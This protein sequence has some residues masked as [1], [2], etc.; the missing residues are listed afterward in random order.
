MKKVV[1]SI[2]LLIFF[3]S[4]ANATILEDDFLFIHHSCGSNWLSDGLH[5]SLLSKPYVHE[6][7]DITYGT[8]L[9]P[10]IGRPDSLAPTP[11][12]KTDMNHWLYW[13]NDYLES[14]KIHG[15][16][17]GVNNIIMFKSCYPTSDVVSDGTEPGNPFSSTKTITNYKSIFRK[18]DG[19]TYTNNGNIYYPL[20]DIF[21]QNPQTLFIIC[22]APPLHQSA[23]SDINGYR[24]RTFNDWLSN[25]WID[26]Y[27]AEYP[28]HDNVMVYD[29][30]DFLA[31]G[32][33]ETP[34]N[35]L[36]T[37]YG[38]TSGDSHPNTF[39]N[40]ESTTHFSP[41]LDSA[42]SL[43]NTYTGVNL[44]LTS[45]NGEIIPSP[46]MPIGGYELGTEVT[47]SAVADSGYH[48]VEWTGDLT[49][50]ANPTI[51]TMNSFKNIVGNFEANPPN[52]Y[53]LNIDIVGNGVVIKEPDT[54]TYTDGQTVILTAM[55]STGWFFESWSG[56][57]ASTSRSVDVI[58]NSDKDI[59]L[60]FTELEDIPGFGIFIVLISL[61][62]I[63]IFEIKRR[64]KK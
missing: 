62:T 63:L 7:N 13:F 35:R 18:L 5:D 53:T 45:T 64:H 39:A 26:S 25:Q 44:I 55:G 47:L 56:N 19:G 10:D 49:G 15:C 16:A 24:V 2:M 60:T 46:T 42:Y 36:K 38:G 30:F 59:T 29:W 22:T 40:Q 43:F 4:T 37:E 51:I 12:D 27:D 11:G 17:D 41:L 28:N 31:T 34:P 54:S 3:V 48:F 61:G 52:Q 1:I 57:I 32:I 33:S 14:I 21:A 20:E 58:M 23:S 9:T 8:D 6:R 50:T